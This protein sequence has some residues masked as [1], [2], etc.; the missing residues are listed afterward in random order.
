MF[1]LDRLRYI[2]YTI[3]KYASKHQAVNYLIF[4]VAVRVTHE[5][6]PSTSPG[7]TFPLNYLLMLTPSP[8]LSIM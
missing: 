7:R 3:C 6:N 1:F 8:P 2:R 5:K 4:G